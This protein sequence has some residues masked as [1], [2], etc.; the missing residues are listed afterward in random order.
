MTFPKPIDVIPH[1]DPFLFLTEVTNLSISESAEG[2]WQLILDEDFF[3][4]HFPE[5]PTLPGG[6]MGESIAQLG[7]YTLLSD[8]NFEGFLPL[9]GGLDNVRFR[10]KVSPGERV[11]LSVELSKISARGGKGHG[12]A[13]VDGE[14]ACSCD[15]MFIFATV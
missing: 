12:E 2:Y 7:A 8:P 13:R 10:R 14:L 5:L 6:L 3:V 15:L 11:E 1:R 4:G 9:F